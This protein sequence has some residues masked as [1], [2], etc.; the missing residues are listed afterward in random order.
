MLEDIGEKFPDRRGVG[1][2]LKSIEAVYPSMDFIFDQVSEKKPIACVF[3]AR[4][5]LELRGHVEN[6]LKIE[7]W[8]LSMGYDKKM[9]G[10]KV[11]YVPMVAKREG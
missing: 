7:S 8:I 11:T 1:P 4:A 10:L 2:V 6:F 9:S 3:V 5:A